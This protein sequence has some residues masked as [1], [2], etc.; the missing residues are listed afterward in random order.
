MV[1]IN[2]RWSVR[3][4]HASELARVAVNRKH[5]I[6][7]AL[8]AMY[9]PG[10]DPTMRDLTG[11][12]QPL[13]PVGTP[14]M[15][16]SQEMGQSYQLNGSGQALAGGD[17]YFAGDLTV[18]G[19]Y[20]Q[21]TPISVAH[22]FAFDN[23]PG[24]PR[25]LATF[26]PAQTYIGANYCLMVNDDLEQHG[27]GGNLSDSQWR[28]VLIWRQG[29]TMGCWLD[30]Q[31]FATTATIDSGS[32]TLANLRLG[33]IHQNGVDGNFFNGEVGPFFAWDRAV[34]QDEAAMLCE[35][36]TRWVMLNWR[37]RRLV[38]TPPSPTF[39]PAWALRSS[40]FIGRGFVPRN[41]GAA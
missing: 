9:L 37:S 15:V 30:G 6:A 18:G 39:N 33:C 3:A 40:R 26:R 7:R 24:S 11:L 20:R 32:L 22:T 1:A 38:S 19:W 21:I 34:A 31:P 12:H 4:P 10:I 35:P 2:P 17:H 23:Y 13:T 14:G 5:P 28:L 36:S 41:Q 29:S 8:K 27:I 25:S 16:W